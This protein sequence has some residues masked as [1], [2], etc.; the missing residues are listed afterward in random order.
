MELLIVP[1][2][3]KGSS[4]RKVKA[5]KRTIF[6]SFDGIRRKLSPSAPDSPF[7]CA[8]A[9]RTKRVEPRIAWLNSFSKER[10]EAT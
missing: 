8:L 6:R 1:Y 10:P 2:S 5:S 3:D 7:I 4:H 9:C